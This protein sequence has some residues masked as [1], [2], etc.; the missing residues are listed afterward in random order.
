MTMSNVPDL[1]AAGLATHGVRYENV[2]PEAE[3]ATY[4]AIWEIDRADLKKVD[5]EFARVRE[6]LTREGRIHSALEVVGRKTWQRI[7]AEF[8]TE[9]SRAD[10]VKGIWIIE[11]TCTDPTR[12]AEFNRW[13]ETTHIPDLLN[14]GLFL[15]AY[16]FVA[17]GRGKYLAIYETAINP[18]EAVEQFVQ[19]HRPRL[20]AQGRL[21]EIINVTQRAAFRRLRPIG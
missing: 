1:L 2:A 10:G 14:T 13:Y 16:R 11:S 6:R 20:R 17:L 5:G 8:V 21:S 4:L 18:L 15:A 9:R 3:A 7:G 12:E 19:L